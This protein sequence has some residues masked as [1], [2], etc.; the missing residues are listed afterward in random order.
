M[1]KH[2]TTIKMKNLLITTTLLL[3][4]LVLF[5]QKDYNIEF[6]YDAAGNRTERHLIEFKAPEK[7][8]EARYK[9]Q[10]LQNGDEVVYKDKLGDK[11]ISIFPNPT[12]GWLTVSIRQATEATSVDACCIGTI[13]VFSLAGEK[14]FEQQARRLAAGLVAEIKIDLSKLPDGTYVLKIMLDSE[15]S[16]WKI[17]KE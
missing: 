7:N 14:V 5:S 8:Q 11:E 2:K 10:E 17:I 13:E 16:T 12:K 4:G 1:N 3:T 9:D 15:V 6:T